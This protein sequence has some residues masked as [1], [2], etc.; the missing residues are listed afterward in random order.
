MTNE[1]IIT[2]ITYLYSLL[3]FTCLACLCASLCLC[4]LAL[5]PCPTRCCWLIAYQQLLLSAITS[6]QGKLTVVPLHG[7]LLL[8]L[9][10]L[11]GL[12]IL[13]T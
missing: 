4:T 11:T 8:A 12:L 3:P 7:C 10:Y 9:L 2:L 13:S 1:N 6:Y 5:T